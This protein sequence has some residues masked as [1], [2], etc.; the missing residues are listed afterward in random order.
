MTDLSTPTDSPTDLDA[1]RARVDEL[2]AA[3]TAATSPEPKPPRQLP[4]VGDLVT[5]TSQ[6]ATGLPHTR[7]AFVVAVDEESRQ[8]LVNWL[9]DAEAQMSVDDLDE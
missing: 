4:K 1:L 9:P 8:A 5:Y 2:Q 6:A 3:L 7:R